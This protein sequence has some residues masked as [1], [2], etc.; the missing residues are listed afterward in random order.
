VTIAGVVRSKR[1]NDAM[2][3]VTGYIEYAADGTTQLKNRSSTYDAD[4][5]VTD[6]TLIQAGSTTTTHNDYKLW[7]G[8]AYAGAD[9]GVIQHSSSV[10]GSVTTHTS[11]FYSWWDEAK[12]DTVKVSATNPT[13]RNAGNWAPGFSKLDYDVNGHVTKLTD[14][15]TDG[16]VDTYDDKV[17]TYQNDAYG[18]VLVRETKVGTSAF[19]SLGPRQLYYYFNGHRIGDV[20]NDD[21]S[22]TQFDYDFMTSRIVQSINRKAHSASTWLQSHGVVGNFVSGVGH[23]VYNGASGAVGAVLHSRLP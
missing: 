13:N 19:A 23:G 10:T 15:G 12:Q 1:T 2:G 3:R 18:Q 16:Q 5:R 22:P 20:G 9:Q 6:E 21:V 4:N 7:N 17:S 11:Y 8:T 14:Y